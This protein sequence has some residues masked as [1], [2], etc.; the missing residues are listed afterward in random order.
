MTLTK[1]LGAVLIAVPLTGVA[2]DDVRRQEIQQA[3]RTAAWHY[4]AH[5]HTPPLVDNRRH[6]NGDF[7]AAMVGVSAAIIIAQRIELEKQK[8]ES[9]TEKPPQNCRLIPVLDYEGE[10]VAYRQLCTR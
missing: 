4:Q 5:H 8:R 2:H 7:W 3:Q 10:V 1:I 9:Q 6:A